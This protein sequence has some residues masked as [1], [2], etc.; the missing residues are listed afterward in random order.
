MVKIILPKGVEYIF[1]R[2]PEQQGLGHAILCAE[3][4]V[5]GEVAV[6]LADDFIVNSNGPTI[7]D[8][9]SA[10][11]ATGKTQLRVLEVPQ[12]D[13]SQYGII[14]PN[15]I[16]SGDDG[17]VEKPDVEEA[18]SN[19]ASIGRY[20]LTPDI[21]DILRNQNGGKIMKSSFLTQLISKLK[22]VA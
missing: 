10:Y 4:A 7:G 21:L 16:K 3:R 2:Q 18:P 1:V 19:L 12:T 17:L 13:V 20:V 6:L 8:L 22:M 11:H 9:I 5:V 15:N 14:V